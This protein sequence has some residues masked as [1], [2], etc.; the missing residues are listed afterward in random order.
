MSDKSSRPQYKSRTI[1]LAGEQ[2]VE[3][4]FAMLRAVPIDPIRPLELVLRER[5][6][7]RRLDQNAAMWAGP[8]RDIADQAWVKLD[9]VS[10]QFSAE[11]WH[12][13]FKRSFLPEDDDPEF[14]DYCK[15]GYCKWA[16]D[17][18]GERVLI[19]STTQLTERGFTN[20]LRQV[21]AL[22]AG[23]GVMFS[24]TPGRYEDTR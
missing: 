16:I 18:A 7:G 20:Y 8:L 23:L 3:L 2:Q 15:D 24:A 22:G 5:A 13:H 21:E 14:E 10:R 11:V 17:P 1:Y 19:G 9:G 6:K 12:E 4:A